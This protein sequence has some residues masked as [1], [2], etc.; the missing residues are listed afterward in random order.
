[1]SQQTGLRTLPY[2]RSTCDSGRISA[3]APP[4]L[5]ARVRLGSEVSRRDRVRRL[6]VARYPGE[7]T[8]NDVLNLFL[9]LRQNDPELLP[10]VEQHIKYRQL[11]ADLDGLYLSEQ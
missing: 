2:I 3:Q 6:F 1:M 7:R 5:C 11:K 9:R 4:M 10:Q 8:A